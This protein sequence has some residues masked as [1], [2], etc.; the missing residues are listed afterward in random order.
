MHQKFR[1]EKAYILLNGGYLCDLWEIGCYTEQGIIF[2]ASANLFSAHQGI[3][4]FPDLPVGSEVRST[5]QS[6]E[7]IANVI[8]QL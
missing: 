7:E 4:V 2:S 5:S 1:Q 6:L 8:R 3:A